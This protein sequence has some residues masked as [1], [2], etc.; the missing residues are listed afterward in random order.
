[1]V[2]WSGDEC[3]KVKKLQY[4]NLFRYPK[5]YFTLNYNFD[6]FNYAGIHRPVYLYTTP[7]TYIDD[8]DVHTTTN[9]TTGKRD[10]ARSTLRNRN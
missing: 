7:E 6:F 10:N 2:I 5:D 9:G 1:M 8:I 3:V 4:L